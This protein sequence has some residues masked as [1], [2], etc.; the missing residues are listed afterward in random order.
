MEFFRVLSDMSR[1]DFWFFGDPL[2][3]DGAEIDARD[4][5]N[6][7]RYA[8]PVPYRVPLTE[9]GLPRAVTL[10]AF[11]MPV[12]SRQI[13]EILQSIC[14]GE[15]ERFPVMV[16]LDG[17]QLEILNAVQTV[18]CVDEKRSCTV[19]FGPDG[20]RPDRA[21]D[22]ELVSDLRIDAERAGNNSIF[23]LAGWQ[24]AL[25]VSNTV[26]QAIEGIPNLGIVFESVT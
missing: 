12:V 26:K 5:T 10:A 18:N 22:Y 19:K 4:F 14:P 11:D 15:I 3:R 16:D 17:E 7:T 24:V 1:A 25:I 8:G 20:P 6:G 9:K 23:R 2:T 13:G 21:G